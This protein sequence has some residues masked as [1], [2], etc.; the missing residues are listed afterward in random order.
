M[1][2]FE[3]DNAREKVIVL[4]TMCFALAMAMLDNTVVNVA[5]PSIKNDLGAGFSQLQWIVDGYVLAFASLLLTGGILGDRYGRK[6]M[7]LTGV[8]VFTLFSFLCGVSQTP[9]QLIAFRALQGVGGALL[10]P[11]TLSIL[12]VTFPVHERAKAL[13]IWAGVSGIA[14]ALGPTLGGYMVEHIGWE[15]VFFLNVPIG[16]VAFIVATR[17]VK[18]SVSEAE[19]QLD[20]TGLVLGTAALFFVTYA[21]I[22][23]NQLGWT[24]TRIVGSFVL[25]AAFLIAFLWWELRNPHAMMPLRYYRIPS[26]SAGNAVAFSVG[27]GMFAT[28]F[29]LTIYM[30]S[31]HGYSPFKSGA[32]FLPMTLAIIATAPNAGRYASTHGSR[33]PMTFGLLLAGVGLILLGV[34]LTPTTSYWMV[35][36]PIY[37]AMGI[38]L[39]AT[40]APMTAAV[41][42]SVGPQRAGLGSAMTN[43]SREVGGVLGI[44]LLGAILTTEL[45]SAFAPA[46]AGLGLNPQ[47]LAAVS[48][49]AQH[50]SLVTS[51]IGLTPTQATGLQQAFNEAFMKGFQP[52]LVF[53]GV[54]VLIAC[55][56]ANRLIPGRETVAQAH[57][58]AAGGPH[59]ARSGR[60]VTRVTVSAQLPGLKT[61]SATTRTS[62]TTS[63]REIGEDPFDPPLDLGVGRIALGC[64]LPES[65]GLRSQE[66]GA[67]GDRG[68][69]TGEPEQHPGIGEVPGADRDDPHPEDQHGDRRR[70]DQP[71]AE[72]PDVLGGGGQTRRVTLPHHLR[73]EGLRVDRAPHPRDRREDVEELQRVV[74][75][76]RD[77]QHRSPFGRFAVSQ[78]RS[79][80]GASVYGVGWRASYRQNPGANQ[81]STP[82]PTIVMSPPDTIEIAGVVRVAT[83][84]DSTSPSDGPVAH[85]AMPIPSKRPRYR[86][87]TA[88][89]MIEIRKMPL[90][91]SPAPAIPSMRSESQSTCERPNTTIAAPHTTI[92]NMIA[93]PCRRTSFARPESKVAMNAPAAGAA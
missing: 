60:D 62:T 33:A 7:F 38:G 21:L 6:K 47:Q 83:T 24:S 3:G 78:R 52:A 16:I 63:M 61:M 70:R 80:P 25:F 39:G 91:M 79:P 20:V 36:F 45:K 9:G 5:L 71:L 28:F 12:T 30:Q 22:E 48:E 89:W 17:T 29:F 8:A 14:L 51:G 92:D 32:G 72:I 37:L 77:G 34:L 81:R 40:I 86:S 41:M 11:G 82:I 84:P 76:G 13:G 66:S 74:V 58:A 44:A 50:G 4:L 19:R 69:D 68:R 75:P 23:A 2:G 67:G 35:L 65:L 85:T 57:A 90:T 1:F 56:V 93:L 54:I 87:S 55:V 10:L 46:V 31:I 26:F 43:T 15:S 64:E 73:R 53:A 42:N 59:G 88:A 27:M 18:E 49:G